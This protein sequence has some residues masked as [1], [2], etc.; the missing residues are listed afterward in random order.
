MLSSK[1]NGQHRKINCV[2]D[3]EPLEQGNPNDTC[4]S[5]SDQNGIPYVLVSYFLLQNIKTGLCRPNTATSSALSLTLPFAL[6]SIPWL[7]YLLLYTVHYLNT[8]ASS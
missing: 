5:Y 4:P 3:A 8:C 6:V 7:E 1:P 2:F